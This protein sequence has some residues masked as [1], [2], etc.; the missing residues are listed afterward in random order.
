VQTRKFIKWILTAMMAW[1]LLAGVIKAPAPVLALSGSAQAGSAGD[2]I[3]AVN[4][5][6]VS[7]G[8]APYDIDGSLMS[9]SQ[10]HSEYQASIQNCTHTREDGSDPAA[11]GI[12]AE[13]IA[14]GANLSVQDAI[15]YQWAD[16]LHTATILGPETGLV[17]A[18]AASDGTSVYYT[19]AVKRL[20]GDF[21]YSPPV[22]NQ[23]VSSGADTG[24]SNQPAQVQETPIGA[25][26]PN[27][28]GS[29]AHIVKY[30][31]TLLSIAD[32]YGLSL[33]EIISINKLD[34]NNPAI[35]EKQVLL[36]RIAFTQTPFMT[37]T[38]TP[39]PP[40]RTPLPTRTPRPTRT[41]GPPRTPQPTW[42]QTPPPL[43]QV[44]ELEDLGLARPILAYGFIVISV[45][46]L[47]WV[48]VAG[49]LMKKKE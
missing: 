5:Y 12:S 46:G 24:S 11:Y 22:P 29:I 42:T 38:Y 19:L 15:Y 6:R 43:V 21:N 25:S 20:S 33:N 41:E 8:L 35:F 10:G 28:D 7:N 3:A 44:P 40:T 9:L 30:G 4:S 16:S 34:P 1:A 39:R 17:G 45:V 14:C 49:F 31:E 47:A 2:L 23:P 32:L 48:I 26:T 18:G 13:N 27:E 37:A 36:I